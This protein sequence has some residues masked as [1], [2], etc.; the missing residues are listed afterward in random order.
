MVVIVVIA[1][2]MVYTYSTGL[3][4]ALLVAPKTANEAMNLEFASFSQ[5]NNTA[6]LYLRNTGPSTV[7]FVSYYVKDWYGNQY[8]K[9]SGWTGGSTI[10]PTTLGQVTIQISSACSCST[11]GNDFTF[12]PGNAYTITLITSRNGAFPLS[13]VR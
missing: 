9:V 2:V 10:P 11:T 6:T 7:T 4:G 1:S 5:N 8:S 3:L 13:V 12:Q